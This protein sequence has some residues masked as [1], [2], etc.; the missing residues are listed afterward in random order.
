MSKIFED[1]D[2]YGI[3]DSDETCVLASL[4]TGE[5][6]L[7]VGPPGTAKTEIIYMIGSAF[8]ELSKRTHPDNPKQWFNFNVYD[9]SKI[10]FEDLIGW[11]NPNALRDGK[12]DFIESPTTIWDK[13][14]IGLDE[15]NRCA[16]DRQAN[17]FEVIRNRTCM[18]SPT[19]VKFIFSAI[20]PYGDAGTNNL[21]SAIIDRHMFFLHFSGFDKMT[22]DLRKKVIERVGSFDS[23]G[24]KHWGGGKSKFTASDRNDNRVNYLLA[25]QG[26]RLRDIIKEAADAYPVIQEQIAGPVTVLIDTLISRLST[27]KDTKAIPSISGRR[28]GMIARAIIAYRSVQ[29][30]RAKKMG[31]TPDSLKN[32]V[33]NTI[34][35]CIPLGIDKPISPDNYTRVKQ[36]VTEV[37]NYWEKT[38]DAD[39]ATGANVLYD[40]YYNPDPISK[41]ELLLRHSNISNLVTTKAWK[42]LAETDMETSCI[43]YYLRNAIP[44]VIPEH[45]MPKDKISQ[46]ESY[47]DS[48][49]KTIELSPACELFVDEFTNL[50]DVRSH[51]HTVT[52]VC[53]IFATIRMNKI[54]KTH[55]EVQLGLK[56]AVNLIARCTE[57]IDNKIKDDAAK[58]KI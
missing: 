9:T 33:L 2:I 38:A 18:G 17:L 35:S 22:S 5:P 54:A 27:E 51:K 26:E 30:A 29:L 7:F 36:I 52:Y 55:Q 57:L 41:L 21:S 28:A 24:L 42:D 14:M 49:L 12:I 10:N 46:I 32:T 53:A 56:I 20:N 25:E 4:L 48:C 31:V 50:L 1:F 47:A 16:E 8:R 23:V 3:P 43:L 37:C 6:T 15:L 11:P 45:V 34:M 58:Q 13:D 44:N 19:Q 40:I 39:N